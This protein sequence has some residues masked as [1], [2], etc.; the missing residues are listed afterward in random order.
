MKFYK[1]KVEPELY[2]WSWSY[3]GGVGAKSIGFGATQ[4]PNWWSHWKFLLCSIQQKFSKSGFRTFQVERWSQILQVQ[5][6]VS[7]VCVMTLDGF[8]GWCHDGFAS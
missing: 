5:R 7:L 8:L 6:V 3:I 2:R 4:E 1:S